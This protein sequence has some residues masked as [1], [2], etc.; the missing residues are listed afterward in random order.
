QAPV[1]KCALTYLNLKGSAITLALT[2]NRVDLLSH[3]GFAKDLNAVLESSN[4]QLINF[5]NINNNPHELDKINPFIINIKNDNCYEYSLRYIKNLIVK[6]SPLWLRNLLI[7]NQ[8]EPT[9]NIMDIINL[10]MI[11]YGIPLNVFDAEKL[12][13]EQIEIRNAEP[14]EKICHINKTYFLRHQQDIVITNNNKIISLSN[15]LNNP[16]YEITNKTQ[17]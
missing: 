8:I 10:I 6:P 13:N 14:N 1:G 3:I 9:N 12:T 7:T 4:P 5:Q 11:E 17:N 2:P 15:I 16:D